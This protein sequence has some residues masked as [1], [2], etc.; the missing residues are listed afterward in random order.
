VQFHETV[1]LVCTNIILGRIDVCE[2][3]TGSCVQVNRASE[4][5]A[6]SAW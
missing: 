3:D 1:F 2:R 6:P 4:A 5:S